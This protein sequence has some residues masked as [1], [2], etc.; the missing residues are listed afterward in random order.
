MSLFDT[1][2]DASEKKLP[3]YAQY[4][5]KQK[6]KTVPKEFFITRIWF[7]TSFDSYGVETEKFRLSVKKDSPMGRLLTA[8]VESLYDTDLAVHLVPYLTEDKAQKFLFRQVKT[9][10]YWEFMGNDEVTYGLGCSPQ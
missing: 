2:V 7:P 8:N 4:L 3:T 5:K 9:K 10:V 1:E 6:G